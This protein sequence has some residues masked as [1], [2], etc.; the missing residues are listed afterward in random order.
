MTEPD[1]PA[2]RGSGTSHEP[3]TDD[4][5]TPERPPE[6]GPAPAQGGVPGPTEAVTSPTPAVGQPAGAESAGT[7]APSAGAE[8]AGAESAGTEAPSEEGGSGSDQMPGAERAATGAE[9]APRTEQLSAAGAAAGSEWQG[10]P[11]GGFSDRGSVPGAEWQG[12]PPGGSPGAGGAWPGYPQGDYPQGYQQ[13][14]WPPPRPTNGMAVASLALGILWIYWI[15]SV[16]ALI[17]GY[18]ARKQIAERG[19]SGAGLATAGIVLGWIGVGVMIV[20]V[21][22]LGIAF[23]AHGLR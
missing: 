20:I 10:Y 4:A 16:L 9:G 21:A 22:G 15:G 1:Q 19:E 2:D 5:R 12:Y 17:F 3:G 6:A 23:V 11:P 8:S 13:P 18:Q 7:E 14:G